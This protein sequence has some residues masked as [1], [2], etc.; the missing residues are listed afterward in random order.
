VA[1][2]HVTRAGHQDR[3]S[4]A[5]SVHVN[6][7]Q[8]IIWFVI[9]NALYILSSPRPGQFGFRNSSI[10]TI[11]SSLYWRPR[12][13]WQRI[14]LQLEAVASERMLFIWVLERNRT[15][16]THSFSRWTCCTHN[17]LLIDVTRI[18][19]FLMAAILAER[20]MHYVV[21]TPSSPMASSVWAS[22]QMN[23]MNL[24]HL[25]KWIVTGCMPLTS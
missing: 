22:W 5:W 13:P 7:H 18:R 4:R 23:Q 16:R 20:F 12:R 19:L 15:S 8:C 24:S 9:S 14:L 2:W 21:S 17:F 6:F 11:T 3:R 25:S 10:P 1:Q